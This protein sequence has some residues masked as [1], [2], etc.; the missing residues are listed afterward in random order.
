MRVGSWETS[1]GWGQQ[2]RRHG[3]PGLLLGL[4]NGEKIGVGGFDSATLATR[5]AAAFPPTVACLV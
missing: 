2:Q 3:P 1:T 4:G 5:P